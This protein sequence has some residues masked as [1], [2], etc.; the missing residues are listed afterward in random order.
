M[1]AKTRQLIA[2]LFL[3]GVVIALLPIFSIKVHASSP[4]ITIADMTTNNPDYTTIRDTVDLI[5]QELVDELNITNFLSTSMDGDNMNVSLDSTR[6]L[7]LSQENKQKVMGICLNG[8]QN[9]GISASNRAKIYNFIADS[10]SAI[11]SLVRQ[12]SNDVTADF[13][14][15]YAS[16]KPFTGVLGWILGIATFAIFTLLGLSIVIDI[17]YIVIP[18]IQWL[19]LRTVESKKPPLISAEAWNAVKESESKNMNKTPLSSY[20]KLKVKE[21][22]VLGVCLL[23]LVSGQLYIL[24]GYI[25]DYFQG[26]LIK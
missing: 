14:H 17:S 25:V 24:V 13:A 10:D 2:L 9:S 6:Y 23:Y 4:T 19:L 7:Q 16:F 20:F 12:L 11:S 21:F 22:I 1:I 3:L 15:A 8:V 5:N 18:P 26:F